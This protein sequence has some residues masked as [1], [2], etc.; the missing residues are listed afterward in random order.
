[1]AS[2]TLQIWSEPGGEI[3]WVSAERWAMVHTNETKYDSVWAGGRKKG[4][5]TV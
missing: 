5:V 2:E 1:M 3:A 4:V